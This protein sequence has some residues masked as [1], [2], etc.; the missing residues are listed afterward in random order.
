[1]SQGGKR[2]KRKHG[3]KVSFTAVAA[4]PQSN[5]AILE[6]LTS[7]HG[8][9]PQNDVAREESLPIQVDIQG[10][11]KVQSAMYVCVCGHEH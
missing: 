4:E 6:G 2:K 1:M 5:V 9:V 8:E 7:T 11:L 3:K 10:A